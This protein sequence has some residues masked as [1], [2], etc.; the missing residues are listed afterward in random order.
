MRF[1]KLHGL[2]NDFVLLDLRGQPGASAPSAQRAAE[3]CDRHRGI[4]AD[5]VLTLLPGDRFVIHNADGSVPEM[6]GNGARCAALWIAT[7]GG[8]RRA[9]VRVVLNT[10]A[11]ARACT[12]EADAPTFG[13]VEVE[14]GAAEVGDPRALPGGFSAV[15]VSTG[16]PHRVIFADGEPRELALRYGPALCNAEDAN[17]EF[18]S[19]LGAGR[20]A[21][22]VWERGAGLTQACGTGA[23][24]VAAAAL[25]R[26]EIDPAAPVIVELPGGALQIRIDQRTRQLRMRGPAQLVYTGDLVI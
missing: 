16:N 26:G 10:D 2:G 15:P 1:G 13:Q 19:R 21:A 5:G 18:V 8:A 23:C 25:A 7:D 6:C 17:I 14:M 9:R 12:V 3:L 24:A 11:G 4:G 20:Y 22:V